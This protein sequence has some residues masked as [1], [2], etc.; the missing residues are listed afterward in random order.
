MAVI[1]TVTDTVLGTVKKTEQFTSC[2]KTQAITAWLS[3]GTAGW[4]RVR[5]QE[6]I[7][8][9]LIEHDDLRIG[10]PTS[11][12]HFEFTFKEDE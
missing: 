9:L 5:D 2:K 6:A 12:T 4:G 8:L 7:V 1:L 3:H 11:D 10:G